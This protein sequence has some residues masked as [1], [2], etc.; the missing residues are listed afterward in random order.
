[1]DYEQQGIRVA[2]RSV[3]VTLEMFSRVQN[4]L[5]LVTIRA[6]PDL[7]ENPVGSSQDFGKPFGLL[8]KFPKCRAVCCLSLRNICR[9]EP[10]G[11]GIVVGRQADFDQLPRAR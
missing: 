2:T 11:A 1:M 8:G 7:Q 6:S 3:R 4:W 5:F 10:G 9:L